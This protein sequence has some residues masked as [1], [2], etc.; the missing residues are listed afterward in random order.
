MD[1]SEQTLCPCFFWGECVVFVCHLARIVSSIAECKKM[2]FRISSVDCL[3]MCF[4][5]ETRTICI[6]GCNWKIF[7]LCCLWSDIF[8]VLLT[9][10]HS[11]SVLL[12]SEL[13]T[14]SKCFFCEIW[15]SIFLAKFRS[16][17]RGPYSGAEVDKRN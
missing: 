1:D 16:K 8:I 7:Y 9:F 14:E 10:S 13:K 2:C 12:A 4:T 5:C 11:N 3:F 6:S 17:L 15:I